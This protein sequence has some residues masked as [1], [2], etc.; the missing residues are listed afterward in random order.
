MTAEP[1]GQPTSPIENPAHGNSQPLASRD[2]DA[3]PDGPYPDPDEYADP[4]VPV[5]RTSPERRPASTVADSTGDV[6]PPAPEDGEIDDLHLIPRGK[7]EC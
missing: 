2:T 6:A 5:R 4:D 1:H 7:P 3:G